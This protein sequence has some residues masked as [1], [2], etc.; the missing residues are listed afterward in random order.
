MASADRRPP[1][2]QPP[3]NVHT[4]QPQP[5]DPN[6]PHSPRP[7][8]AA[9]VSFQKTERGERNA[10]LSPPPGR[11]RYNQE[12][13]PT[14]ATADP[15]EFDGGRVGR[16]KSLVRPDREKIEP[17]HRQWHYR[18]QAARLENEGGRVT[19]M[20]SSQSSY[21]VMCFLLTLQSFKKQR[22]TCLIY[23]R[24][25][26]SVVASPYW[27]VIRTSTSRVSRF[28]SEVPHC[29]GDNLPRPVRLANPRPRTRPLA[30]VATLVQVPKMLG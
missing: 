7:R 9:A 27:V 29:E 24:V 30:A 22:A 19:L 18:N 13:P 23:P 8:P 11:T 21:V 2:S 12:L 17:G 15:R 28:S 16:K 26:M 5:L 3:A 6:P 25:P 14:P 1:R 4:G 10:P 20:P